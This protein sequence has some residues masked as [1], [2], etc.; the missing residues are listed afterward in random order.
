MSADNWMVCPKCLQD[1][2]KKREKAIEKTNAQYGKVTAEAFRKAI[3]KAEH[4]V[5]LD[6]T[7]REDYQIGMSTDGSF[8]VSYGG[9]CKQCGFEHSHEHSEQV[10]K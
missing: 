2:E 1:E 7:F 10:L 8:M 5:A 4:P 3:E 6:Q 9:Y